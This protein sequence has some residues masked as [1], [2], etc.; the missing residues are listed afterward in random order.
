MTPLIR[1]TI[2]AL[3]TMTATLALA[4]PF[5]VVTAGGKQCYY[6][7][8]PSCERAAAAARGACVIN[9]AETRTPSGGAPFCVV[10]SFGTQ[11]SYYDL[12][13]CQNAARSARGT[14]AAR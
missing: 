1:L 9:Q 7:D 8:E 12:Q 4:A 11:C 6:M 14:C 2:T 10:S 3:L 13:Q 5:C